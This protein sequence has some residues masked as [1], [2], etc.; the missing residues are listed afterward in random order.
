MILKEIKL[1]N[2]T[3]YESFKC[4]LS[5][6]VNIFIGDNGQGKSNLL[7]SIY[8]VACEHSAR[9]H[10]DRDMI[11]WGRDYF[12]I[13]ASFLNKFG[14]NEVE[15]TYNKKKKE[16]KKTL[17]LNQYK[18][19]KAKDYV[20]YFNAVFFS[21]EDLYI[22]K[23]DPNLRRKYLDDELVQTDNQYFMY[24][25]QYKKV[26]DQRNALLKE[27]YRRRSLLD[28][29]AVWEEQL[30]KYGTFLLK[31]RLEMVHHLKNVAGD[32]HSFLTDGEETLD[33]SYESKL[34]VSLLES[35][36]LAS[37]QSL[38]FNQLK[39]NRI[40]DLERGYTQL[41]PHRDD[42]GLLINGMSAKKF[43]SQGQQRTAALSLKIAEVEL[44]NN[45]KGEYPILL[46][47][48]VLSELDKKRKN[49][50]FM[51]LEKGIQTVI[52]ST[53]LND[54]EPSISNKGKVFTIEKGNFKER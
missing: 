42:L 44:I 10:K 50:L 39:E 37:F 52:T 6:G 3:N 1:E 30:S 51:R 27:A 43:G 41:G 47:D 8:Y 14:L 24:L 26:L 28:S 16:G 38:Y 53:D 31:C 45:K 21:P 54:I 25:Y 12:K 13:S 5:E 23:G 17:L 35:G 9:N 40:T 20:G 4:A 33:V 48:D 18:I 49:K 7:D 19:E 32:I 34:P 46:L 15:I 29:M 22:V 36:Q 11:L 2:F